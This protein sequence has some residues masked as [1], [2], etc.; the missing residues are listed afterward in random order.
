MNP[1]RAAPNV[2]S[3]VVGYIQV[4]PFQ[5]SLERE[6]TSQA[7][8]QDKRYLI[9]IGQGTE[10]GGCRETRILLAPDG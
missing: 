5:T 2:A 7:H 1:S 6:E 9:V 4:P 10:E 3:K 8:Q